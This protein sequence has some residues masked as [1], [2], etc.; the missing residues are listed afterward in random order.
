[1][2][3]LSNKYYCYKDA[4][5]M[6]RQNIFPKMFLCNGSLGK[7]ID[8]IYAEGQKPSK[9]MPSVIIVEFDN[10]NADVYTPLIPAHPNW[11]PIVPSRFKMRDST[12]SKECARIQFPIPLASAIT[13]HKSQGQTLDEVVIDIGP[14]E[15]GGA[16]SY[17][18]LSRV[19][20]W[21]K[22]H[23][24][25]FDLERYCSIGFTQNGK[26]SLPKKNLR[27]IE[28][29]LLELEEK[30]KDWF[31]KK[32]PSKWN[33]DYERAFD[34][35]KERQEELKKPIKLGN[36]VEEYIEKT[37][38][39]EAAV[40]AAAAAAAN[41]ANEMEP[42]DQSQP[43]KVAVEVMDIDED[44]EKEAEISES[45]ER[46]DA[47]NAAMQAMEEMQEI[48]EIPQDIDMELVNELKD[49]FY[50]YYWN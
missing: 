6:C 18:A 16:L 29:Y 42:T 27:I 19:K 40:A 46:R 13:I 21:A 12:G 9:S 22:L 37:K 11:V 34:K 7:V 24:K 23:L 31:Q 30:T 15:N 33:D 28:K 8:V 26:E 5:V 41:L 44:D 32:Y 38:A 17:V 10:I 36:I 47:D 1:M 45:Q 2:Y 20:E 48:Q 49:F 25:K 3:S 39:A 4:R 43:K 35:S 50:F 14:K